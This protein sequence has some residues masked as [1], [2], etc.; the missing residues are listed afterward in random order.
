MM[1][2]KHTLTFDGLD[3][4]IWRSFW[5]LLMDLEDDD[6]LN[7]MMMHDDLEGCGDLSYTL[8]YDQTL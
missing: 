8:G 1:L 7:K 3:P 6:T 2:M 4:H 5:I